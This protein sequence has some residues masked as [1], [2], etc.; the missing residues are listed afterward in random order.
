MPGQRQ[1]LKKQVQKALQ[2]E[3]GGKRGKGEEE[4]TGG[5]GGREREERESKRVQKRKEGRKRGRKAER[6]ERPGLV[7]GKSFLSSFSGEKNSFVT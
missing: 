4:N 3:E 5:R 6:K 2:K 1:L 7:L